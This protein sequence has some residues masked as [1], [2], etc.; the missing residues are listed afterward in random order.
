MEAIEDEE[1]IY[2]LAVE[3]ERLFVQ[4]IT[5]L[6]NEDQPNGA[7]ILSE[8]S[9]RFAAWTAFLGVFAESNVCLDRRLR[10]HVE[11][12]DQ[13]LLL[14]D[15]MLRSLT[16]CVSSCVRSKTISTNCIRSF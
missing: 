5:R 2:E 1:P 3:C 16:H 9:L 8:L 11:I 12:Q 14:L 15:I 7:K 6:K 4:Q 13:V 10:R